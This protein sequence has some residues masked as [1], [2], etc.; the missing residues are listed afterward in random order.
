MYVTAPFACLSAWE[1]FIDGVHYRLNYIFML[2]GIYVLQSIQIV[3]WKLIQFYF[4][5]F[6][7]IGFNVYY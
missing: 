7:M 1:F 3:E 5:E 6:C 4:K 2:S